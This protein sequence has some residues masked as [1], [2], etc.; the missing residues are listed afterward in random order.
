MEK[1]FSSAPSVDTHDK[2]EED[3]FASEEVV[4]VKGEPVI[5]T[6]LD[7]S[8]FLVD[9]RGD[10]DPAITFRSMVIGTVFAGLGAALCEVCYSHTFVG[11]YSAACRTDA[12]Y[13]FRST[14]SSLP[15]RPCPPSSSCSSYTRS[16]LWAKYLPRASW[17]EST[18]FAGL[19]PV[20]QFINPGEFRIK[21]VS[22][23]SMICVVSP[24]SD[25]G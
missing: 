11:H 20:L 22:P 1:R 18:R 24:R 23:L 10:G 14:C 13:F 12:R 3:A 9:T 19:A 4:Y 15:R 16:A 25:F 2:L 5:T 21:E 8:R 7:V 6:G 17:V